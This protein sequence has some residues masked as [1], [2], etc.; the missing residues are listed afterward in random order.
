MNPVKTVKLILA[1]DCGVGKTTLYNHFRKKY[2]TN[3]YY[4]TMGSDF[5][6]R[7]MLIDNIN[8]NVQLCDTSGQEIFKSF[9]D[10]YFRNSHGVILIFDINNRK[11]FD[12]I[13]DWINR[14]SIN[15]AD[16]K[17]RI[18]LIANKCDHLYTSNDKS[19]DYIELQSNYSSDENIICDKEIKELIDRY[20]NMEYMSISLQ[21]DN[22]VEPIFVKLMKNIIN[23]DIEIKTPQPLV[24]FDKVE[25]LDDSCC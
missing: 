25:E 19:A 3:D 16:N 17:F 9:T 2:F 1:G 7:N 23:S 20:P 5:F 13:P 14:V 11:S 22:H 8:Y 21:Y 18:L 15:I 6:M 12:N 24:V 10:F 4:A